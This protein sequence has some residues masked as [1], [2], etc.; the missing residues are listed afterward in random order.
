M[1]KTYSGPR[2]KYRLELLI[3]KP[4]RIVWRDKVADTR[5]TDSQPIS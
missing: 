5:L 3:T 2:E 1:H 4:T